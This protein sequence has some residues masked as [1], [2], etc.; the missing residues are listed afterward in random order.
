MKKIILC[1][2]FLC[3]MGCKWEEPS[4]EPLM[5]FVEGGS[6]IMGRFLGDRNVETYK[7]GKL[8]TDDELPTHK[9]TVSSFNICKYE[10]T[11]KQYRDFCEDTGHPQPKSFSEQL[12]DNPVMNVTW[13]DAVD[14][15]E[16]LSDKTGKRYRLPTEAEWEYAA[17]GGKQSKGTIFAGSS[18]ITNV[19]YYDGNSRSTPQNVGKLSPN[20]LGLYD[21][22]GNVWEWCS[23]WYGPYTAKE[24]VDPK[25]PAQPIPGAVRVHRGGSYRYGSIY[26][27][28][29]YRGG[30]IFDDDLKTLNV[31]TFTNNTLGFRVAADVE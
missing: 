20:E 10:V 24:E 29:T 8:G 27:R 3:C 30:P 12:E 7:Q 18:L 17:R 1:L 21:M 11:V 22:S 19:G 15:C 23:D 31:N 25:G 16:W 14:Y 13:Q 28:I 9:V 6:F 4:L 26:C 2:S 5:V